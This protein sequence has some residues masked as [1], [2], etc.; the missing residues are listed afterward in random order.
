MRTFGKISIFIIISILFLGCDQKLEVTKNFKISNFIL[1][2]YNKQNKQDF[3]LIAHAGGGI[4]GFN[5]TNSIE[6]VNNSILNG[7]NLIEI[8]LIETRDAKLVGAH[9]WD[10]FKSISNCCKNNQIPS[11]KEF[12]NYK[13]YKDLSTLDYSKINEIFIKNKNLIL[14]TD[15]TNNFKLINNLFTFDKDRIIVEIFGRDN[16]FKAIEENIKNP[17]YSTN[18]GEL[19]FVKKYNIKLIAVHSKDFIANKNAYIEL[20]ENGT[21]IFVYTSNDVKFIYKNKN[22][23][24]SFYSDFIDIK[25]NKCVSNVCETY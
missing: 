10:H 21:I 14:V 12:K 20:S 3:L 9:D 18:I 8:D 19:D 22:I 7:Y 25:N 6:A 13:I 5:Y 1:E 17:M 24:N 4:N 2:I 16:Y 23:V 11:L 15:K